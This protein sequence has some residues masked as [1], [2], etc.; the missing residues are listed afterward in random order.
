METN[1]IK[2]FIDALGLSPFW[3]FVI[4]LLILCVFHY[5]KVRLI[6]TDLFCWLA[7]TVGWFKRTATKR[8][9]EDVCKRSIS[10]ISQEV[11]ELDLPELSVEWVAEKDKSINFKDGEAIV[12]L[13]Y[14][15]DNSQNI[16][17]ATSTYVKETL[18]TL[19]KTYMPAK[20]REAIDY[21]VIRKCLL[22]MRTNS[23]I[24]NTYL[25]DSHDLVIQN[26]AEIEKVSDIDDA[27][28]MSRILFREYFEWGNRIFG[29]TVN[30]RYERE[31]SD[32]LDFLY[33]IAS[34]GFDDYT[35][36]QF[37]SENIKVGVLLV[38]KIETF[39]E[40]GD[41][42]YVRRIKEGFAKGINT[43]YLL[44]RNEKVDIVNEVYGK[45]IST[46]N[47]N[48]LNGPK[49]YKDSLGRENICYCIEINSSGDI[50]QTYSQINEAIDKRTALQAVITSV[51]SDVLCCLINTVD[52]RVPRENITKEEDLRLYR[53]FKV[54]MT[55]EFIPVEL[56]I[57]GVVVG[58]V[59]ETDSNP[60]Q[61][62]NNQ[63]CVGSEILAVVED[64]EDDF[65]KL[66]VKNSDMPA[67]AFRRNLTY[68]HYVFLHHK[69]PVGTEHLFKIIDVD[70]I[71]SRLE[72]QLASLKDP[73][74]DLRLHLNEE[75]TFTVYQKKQNCVVTEISEGVRAILPFT[76]TSWF[77]VDSSIVKTLKINSEFKARVKAINAEERI[78]VLT[79]RTQESPYVQY[80]NTMGDRDYI[81]DVI[82]TSSDSYG[83][84]GFVEKKYRVFIPHGETSIGKNVY[85]YKINQSVKVKLKS[86][87]EDRR[88][89]IGTFKPFITHPLAWFRE[90]YQEGMIMSKLTINTINEKSVLFDIRGKAKDSC[91][92]L[93][94]ISEITALGYMGSLVDIFKNNPS[95]PLEILDIDME[96]CVVK[97]S[98]KKVLEKNKGRIDNLQYDQ[99][100]SA[101]VIKNDNNGCVIVIEKMWVEGILSDPGR[102]TQGDIVMVR[103]ISRGKVPEFCMD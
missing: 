32:F 80:F 10:G 91:L 55:I 89:F 87:S 93:L 85:N 52:V 25:E 73:W 96:K 77:G 30:E 51:H 64:A 27:G 36:L 21:T 102:C 78:V 95:F 58:S 56:D 63:F 62:I 22:G 81:V 1:D 97:L 100:Y 86:V 12:Y 29:R 24:V 7:K 98:L 23:R 84:I 16:I 94:P 69:F 2:G 43:F 14:N 76:E 103:P 26:Q 9:I 34:R 37:I 79:M 40:K 42:P 83:V 18:L 59:L 54:G 11:P 38:A 46:G 15:A 41:Q 71:A 5:D 3:A 45:L 31:A 101:Y 17:N 61:M 28:L 99:S 65:I 44:A 68:S 75:F 92:G 33:E 82:I 90:E 57:N 19:S 50:A 47:Y 35:R 49:V 60:E 67:I 6:V 48:L 20:I 39:I 53:Y 4:L 13:K 74:E 70:Y 66:R 88:S 8:K 72:L